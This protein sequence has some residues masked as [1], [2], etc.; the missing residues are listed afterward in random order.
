MQIVI[1]G[2]GEGMDAAFDPTFGRAPKLLVCNLDDARCYA[3]DNAINA[4]AAAGAGL[5]AAEG[6]IRLGV[7]AVVTGRCGPKAIKLLTAAG[8]GVYSA[9]VGTVAEALA[10]YR[11][12]TL[13][14]IG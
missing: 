3:I 1:S 5:E 12:G 14:R 8:I 2:R 11:A 6:V 4:D 13:E 7:R 9:E 10:Q